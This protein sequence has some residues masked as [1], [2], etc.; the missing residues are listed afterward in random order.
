MKLALWS[1]KEGS[2]GS[3]AGGLAERRICDYR[4]E[5]GTI[6]INCRDCSQT[7]TVDNVL[8]FKGMLRI[9]SSESGVREVVLCKDWEIVYDRECVNVLHG[10][11]DVVRFC[12]GLVF[13]LPFEECQACSSNPRSIANKVI[14]NL[15]RGDAGL[16]TA[17]SLGGGGK[18]LACDNCVRTTRSN[19]EHISLLL[20]EAE[21]RITRTAFKVVPIV[22]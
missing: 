17:F 4:K 9:I 15:P 14:D 6:K 7:P 1:R 10:V 21:R 19:L 13:H 12:S 18:G 2:D 5:E 8:C 16:V 22:D 20:N 11:T 3:S